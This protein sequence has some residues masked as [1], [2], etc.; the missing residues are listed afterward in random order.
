M[1]WLDTLKDYA[2]SI[3]SAILT[4]GAT[5]PQLA[6][7]AISDALGVDVQTMGQAQAAVESADPEVL[8]ELKHADHSFKIEMARIS[9]ELVATELED[10]QDA[11][12]IHKHS[13]MPAVICCSLTVIVAA[14]LVA[15]FKYE[16][17]EQNGSIIYMVIGQIITLWGGSIVYHIGTTRSSAVKTM[18]ML[19]SGKQ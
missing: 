5:A 12:E 15:L 19:K 9:N 2:P 13:V 10:I 4:G 8:L 18:A 17:P 11:R 16:I 7:K 3:A 6:Y 14:L 1:S